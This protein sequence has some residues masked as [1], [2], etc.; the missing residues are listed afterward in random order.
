MHEN[1]VS[2]LSQRLDALNG[3]LGGIR[4]SLMENEQQMD[5]LQK[6]GDL[7]YRD[8]EGL[9]YVVQTGETPE[10][11]E[12]EGLSTRI[13]EMNNLLGSLKGD[14]TQQTSDEESRYLETM[15]K[16]EEIEQGQGALKERFTM[17]EGVEPPHVEIPAELWS[18]LGD[19]ESTLGSMSSFGVAIQEC[20]ERLGQI[21]EERD[22]LKVELSEATAKVS[23]SSDESR[24]AHQVLEE[25]V[26]NLEEEAHRLES[27]LVG[28]VQGLSGR[29]E[30]SFARISGTEEMIR[31]AFERLDANKQDLEGLYLVRDEVKNALDGVDRSISMIRADLE[32]NNQNLESLGMKGVYHEEQTRQ[33][34]EDVL[35]MKEGA[36]T[37]K[38]DLKEAAES[39]QVQAE[40]LKVQTESLQGQTERV[41]SLQC[42]MGE[43]AEMRGEL[44]TQ[45]SSSRTEMESGIEGLK[46][47]LSGIRDEIN[48]L[49][50]QQGDL[51]SSFQRTTDQKVEGVSKALTLAKDHL[52]GE[53]N[54][55]SE[56]LESL[57]KGQRELGDLKGAVEDREKESRDA[58]QEINRLKDHL[59]VVRGDL[60]RQRLFGGAL[61]A[62]AVAGFAL[63]LT[64]GS[65]S[66]DMEIKEM[67]GPAVAA[68]PAVQ[69]NWIPLE[70]DTATEGEALEEDVFASL[71]EAFEEETGEM[72]EEV[73]AT[74]ATSQFVTTAFAPSEP[75]EE[76]VPDASKVVDYVVQDGESLWTIA[77]KHRTEKPLMERIEKIKEDNSLES[78]TIRPGQVLRIFL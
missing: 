9:R 28:E 32:S 11:P 70:D 27:R 17:L 78:Q 43:A 35:G 71:E 59:E 69:E 56:D 44:Q 8:M 60:G 45:I 77:R 40:S 74:E 54:K 26:T 50:Q 47:E 36:E 12:S 7:L 15:E 18:R 37:L 20:R 64:F 30:Q 34:Q 16:V 55:M 23:S 14:L 62:C 53:R 73:I 65:S 46:F 5:Q 49:L 29:L 76:A 1:N 63:L 4:N 6:K 2:G 19:A 22:S 66:D 41:S 31:S 25:T 52:E 21:E 57:R 48:Q 72:S 75:E 24:G 67:V 3:I 10:N 58:R 68:V 38:A 51:E 39:L 42:E 13:T 33:I 61:A